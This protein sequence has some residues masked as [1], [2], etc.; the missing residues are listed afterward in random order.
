M[1]EENLST[2]RESSCEIIRR[3]V[4]RKRIV[5]WLHWQQAG[6]V[7]G[8]EGLELAPSR[9]LEE[10]GQGVATIFHFIDLVMMV[11]FLL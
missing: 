4:N 2:E 5:D 11:V 8:V 9:L 7:V 1:Q 3:L 10:V 6:A